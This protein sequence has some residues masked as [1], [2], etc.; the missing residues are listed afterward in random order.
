ME[1]IRI[2]IFSDIHLELINKL[3]KIKPSCDYLI[4][5]GDIGKINNNNLIN[6][7]NYCSKNWKKTFYILGNHEYYIKNSNFTKINEMYKKKI[8]ELFTNVYLLN[9]EF[10]SINDNVNI[11]GSTLWTPSVN[12]DSL[13]DYNYIDRHV[14]N[15]ISKIQ[16]NNLKKYLNETTTKTIV[17]THFPPTQNKTSD[18]IYQNQKQ[19][20]K[21]YFS[22][23]NL[24]HE[25]VK[26]NI[27]CWISGH[28][29]YSYDFTENNIRCISNQFGYI[30][31]LKN[32]Y[33]KLET[34]CVY[35]FV[36]N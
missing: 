19:D 23:R 26:D 15:S 30:D 10:I 24:L 32:G 31:E 12:D 9:D 8:G 13:N 36:I 17:V 14:V 25:V 22:H 4:L 34:E 1:K 33:S 7:L 3:P 20:I 6:F 27:V 21:D 16:I 5:A 35:E 18:P 2:Q 11:Y 29:H 28:T